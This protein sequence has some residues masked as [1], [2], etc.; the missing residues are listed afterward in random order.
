MCY[1]ETRYHGCC[2]TQV[3]GWIYCRHAVI[4]KEIFPDTQPTRSSVETRGCDICR[5]SIVRDPALPYTAVRIS[6]RKTWNYCML[7]N[8]IE[9]GYDWK[10]NH[11][12]C[13]KV[14]NRDGEPKCKGCGDL[15]DWHC[16]RWN[17]S[18]LHFSP[19]LIRLPRE[20]ERPLTRNQGMVARSVKT[21][22]FTHGIFLSRGYQKSTLHS[23]TWIDPQEDCLARLD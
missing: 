16:S 4:S 12:G 5:R 6:S 2:K 20:Q 9:N 22:T 23:L 13:E 11:R 17:P 1:L 10:C 21:T 3:A 18:M 7:E 14:I 15:L 19:F 8:V